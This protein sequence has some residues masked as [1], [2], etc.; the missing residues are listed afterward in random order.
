[1]EKQK[2]SKALDTVT[3]KVQEKEFKGGDLS[4]LAKSATAVAPKIR[5]SAADLKVL[6][7]EFGLHA[8]IVSDV[9]S[10][11]GGDIERTVA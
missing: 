3:D 5:P 4:Q 1:M 10:A 9:Y 6:T 8:N 7:T 2:Q 11:N